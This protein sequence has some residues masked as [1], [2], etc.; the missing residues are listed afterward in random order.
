ML[1]TSTHR[2]MQCEA[3]PVVATYSRTLYG[4][5]GAFPQS[6][7]YA[8]SIQRFDETKSRLWQI[9]VAAALV[10]L[11]LLVVFGLLPDGVHQ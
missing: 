5:Q 3:D 7:E 2:V 10:A 1:N 6:V 4:S 11:C 9:G 8:E